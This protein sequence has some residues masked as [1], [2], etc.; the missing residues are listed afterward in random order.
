MKWL[1]VEPGPNFSVFD[2]YAGWVEAL[3]ELGE[4]VAEYNTSAR[5]TFYDTA[6]LHKGPDEEPVKALTEDQVT[7]LAINGLYAALYRLRPDVLLVISGFFTPAEMLDL[8]ARSGTLVV[9]V[10]T[11]SPYEDGRQIELAAHAHV[12][13]INDPVHI[14]AF[15]AVCANTWYVPHSFRPSI[16]SPGPARPDLV[17]DFV[18][19]GTGYGSRMEFLRRMELKGLDAILAGNWQGLTESS[20]LREY[21]AHDID[22][23]VDNATAVEL[24]RSSRASINLYRREASAP[25]LAAGWAMGPREV[26][27]AACGLFFL[28]DPR[29]EGD[30][31]LPMLPRFSTPEEAGEL[32]RWWLDH[33]NFRAKA[34]TAAREAVQDRTFNTVAASLIRTIHEGK[35]LR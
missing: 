5:L 33:E 16:H 1:V 6:L 24:Y 3:R 9:L 35:T 25:G 8:V 19:V 11:E 7:E 31:L 13:L 23:C 27:M 10:H 20:P 28:R 34:A 22:Q 26:E 4:D 30:E 29:P 14:E 12:N 2:V 21:V 17:S 32:L 15:R 18:F